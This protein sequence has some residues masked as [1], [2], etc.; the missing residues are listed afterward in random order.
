MTEEQEREKALQYAYDMG[1]DAAQQG[2]NAVN[3]HYTI[4]CSQERTREWERGH[5]AGAKAKAEGLDH[6]RPL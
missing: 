1:Y 4:F 3:C 2:A 6:K 5:A